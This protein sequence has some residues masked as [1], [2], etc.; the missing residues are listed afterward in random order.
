M[1]NKILFVTSGMNRGGAETQ[2]IKVALFLKSMQYTVKIISLTP[3]NEFEIDYEKEG[4][5]VIFLKSW[6]GN[7]YSN[8]RTLYVITKNY[9]PDVVIAFM[10]IAII[11]ARLLKILFKFKLISSIRIAALPRKWY[12]PFKITNGLDDEIVYNS[13]ASKTDFEKKR[14]VSIRGKV[15]HNSISIPKKEVILNVKS[16]D[17]VWTCVAHFRWNKDYKTLFRAIAMLKELNF[18]VD[19]IGG[20]NEKYLSWAELMIKDLEI[21]SHVRILG[22]KSNAQTYLQQSDAF[23]LSSFSEGMPNALLEAMANEKPVVVTDIEC[24][25]LILESAECGFLSERENPTD[26]ANKMKALMAL[27]ARQ[28]S[29][30]GEKGKTYIA[31]NFSEDAVMQHWL[32]AV[33]SI[34]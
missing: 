20:L 22:F 5:P 17:F 6:Q 10:F 1:E 2:L 9:K 26:L 23:V 18:R 19:I 15:I 11:F 31:E 34:A 12:I 24:N 13:V 25:R 16:I 32:S 8:L 4:I 27:S 30:M 33:R 21:E 29:A 28:R 3:I 14:L 7:F